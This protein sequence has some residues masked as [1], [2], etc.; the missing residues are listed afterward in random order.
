MFISRRILWSSW[1]T[2]WGFLGVLV[3]IWA[4]TEP[5]AAAAAAVQLSFVISWI[6]LGHVLGHLGTIWGN[7]QGHLWRRW[8]HLGAYRPFE[9]G[10]FAGDIY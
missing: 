7:Y 10:N 6:H 8:G 5:F 2:V 1:A 3:R 9:N 4:R